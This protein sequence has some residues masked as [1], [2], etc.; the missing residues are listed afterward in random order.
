MPRGGAAARRR[1]VPRATPTP[2]A[3]WHTPLPAGQDSARHPA[4][5]R[6]AHAVRRRPRSTPRAAIGWRPLHRWS[7]IAPDRTP[8][9]SPTCTYRG[10]PSAAGS[11][12]SR[13]ASTSAPIRSRD[14]GCRVAG[15]GMYARRSAFRPS[16]PQPATHHPQPIRLPPA[17]R[18][19]RTPPAAARAPAP[20]AGAAH[21]SRRSRSASSDAG[22]ADHG[23]PPVSSGSRRS[24][25]SRRVGKVR[26]VTRAAASSIARGTPSSRRQISAT[27]G[28]LSA[29]TRKGRVHR[30]APPREQ[31]HCW[32]LQQII[33]R[34]LRL[35]VGHG[36]WRHRENMLAIHPCQH[37]AR[38][39]GREPRAGRQQITQH[40][41]GGPDVLEVIQHQ[42]ELGFTQ[43]RRQSALDRGI[44]GVLDAGGAGH[45]GRHQTG[46]PNL[47][48]RNKQH[49]VGEVR[50][51]PGRNLAGETGLADAAGSGEGEEADV[52]AAPERQGQVQFTLAPDQR[53][54]RNR[55]RGTP[56]WVRWRCG[57]HDARQYAPVRSGVRHGRTQLCAPGGPGRRSD[58]RELLDE[59]VVRVRDVSIPGA[60]D[61]DAFRDHAH[62]TI[63]TTRSRS[64]S[65]G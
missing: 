41:G 43:G 4:A 32:R 10:V 65:T 49:T 2:P 12:H 55:R 59:D 21:G 14:A 36:Q 34:G 40:G 52:T 11:T 50:L 46:V 54:E 16:F 38:R 45:H 8:G 64:I 13:L 7:P 19:R 20:R 31:L 60:I 51:H 35:G 62:V 58:R 1:R 39:Q 53:R 25:R 6:S 18:R 3:G 26:W 24:R 63:T 61:G 56:R 28:A 22:A 9:S 30:L 29:V 44:T 27:S 48:E 47:G 15:C 57:R 17:W 23:P 5:T 33:V 37:S 42:Q